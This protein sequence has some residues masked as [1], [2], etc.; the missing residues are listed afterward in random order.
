MAGEGG[1]NHFVPQFY[2]R[3]WSADERRINLFNFRRMRAIEG[4][5]SIRDQCQLHNFYGFAPDLE[6]AFGVLEGQAAEVIR[7]LKA[8]AGAPRHGSE[9]WRTLLAYIVFQHLR[10]A[11]MG[12]MNNVMTDYLAKLQLEGTEYEK[13]LD[14][15][16][17]ENVY[18]AALPLSQVLRV[19]PLAETL[20]MHLFINDTALELI[21][22]DDP[23]VMHNQYCEGITYQGVT[24]WNC[25]GL[26]VFFPLSPG[27]LV[28]LFDRDTYKVGRSHRGSSATSITDE[29][30]TAQLNSLQILNAQHNIYYAGFKGSEKTLNECRGLASRRPKTRW[31]FVE[32]EPADTGPDSSDALLHWYEP[33]LP[34]R[35][36]VSKISI[37]KRRRQIPL[38]SRAN[39]YR[40]KVERTKEE[41]AMYARGPQLP[42][43]RYPVKKIIH[44]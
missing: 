32:T 26:Q 4:V 7:R 15:L 30:D 38:P 40:Q 35:L 25:A 19:L 8:S 9:D 2:L 14:N 11:N 6:T 17:F 22:S 41:L 34:V 28:M 31:T 5:A 42:P 3:Y 21:T 10:T 1:D 37:R 13:D 44:R 43:G 29:R 12:H 36:N 24:G 27:E 39:L 20:G 18:P 23:V 16:I 33:M